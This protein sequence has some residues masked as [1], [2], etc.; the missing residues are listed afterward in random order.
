MVEARA[1]RG[2][3]QTRRRPIILTLL[4]PLVLLLT[5]S[6]W[7]QEQQ[8][9]RVVN[10]LSFTGQRNISEKVL[11]RVCIEGPVFDLQEAVGW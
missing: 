3:G 4:P 8:R 9:G 10:S 6:L 5:L 7:T 2:H 11:R 1:R